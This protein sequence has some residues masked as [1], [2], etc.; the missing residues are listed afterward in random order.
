MVVVRRLPCFVPAWWMRWYK[1]YVAR[2]AH[3]TTTWGVQVLDKGDT[4]VPCLVVGLLSPVVLGGTCIRQGRQ[5]LVGSK[6]PS[7]SS[8][9][10]MVRHGTPPDA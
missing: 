3:W 4:K 8:F 7:R 1:R 6:N 5:T 9:Q 2:G 10:T